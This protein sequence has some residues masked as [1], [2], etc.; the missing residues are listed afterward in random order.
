[1]KKIQDHDEAIRKK[2]IAN[3]KS[4]FKPSPHDILKAEDFTKRLTSAFQT[5]A[6]Q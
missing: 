1:M 3:Q 6:R 4:G 5:P 2:Y